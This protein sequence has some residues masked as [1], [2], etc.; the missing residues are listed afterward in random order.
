MFPLAYVAWGVKQENTNAELGRPHT[1]SHPIDILK[2]RPISQQDR[3]T[4]VAQ[5]TSD[6]A[7][8]PSW[9]IEQRINAGRI[10]TSSANTSSPSWFLRQDQRACVA[11]GMLKMP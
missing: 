8:R 1:L 9:V 5:I 10:H 2:K 11:L 6:A 4:S 3:N 7:S